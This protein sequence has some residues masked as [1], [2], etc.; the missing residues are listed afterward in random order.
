MANV[1]LGLGSN[2][3]DRM[4]NLRAA[5]DGLGELLADMQASSI[6]RSEALLPQ[7]APADWNCEFLNMAVMG[8]TTLAPEMLLASIKKLEG[9]M[10]RQSRGHWG[11]REIDIDILA[12]D[13]VVMDSP[14]L[15]IPHKELL[16]R[17]FALVP[18]CELAP[19][20]CFPVAGDFFSKTVAEILRAK[21]Y[22]LTCYD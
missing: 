9:E 10:G 20:W 11:P 14:E 4:T 1:I 13:D 21:N 2:I 15:T 6:Y 3:G 17:D 16:N 18:L 19:D 5:Q 22:G 12:Y 8:K 7:N